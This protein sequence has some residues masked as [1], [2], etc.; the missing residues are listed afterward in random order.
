LKD[1]GLYLNFPFCLK[2]C[3]YCD[4]NSFDGKQDLMPAY[5]DA[6]KKEISGL[7]YMLTDYSIR[8]IY[9]GGGTPTLFHEDVLK[10]ILEVCNY[11]LNVS[12]DA[13]I[14][15]ESNPATLNERKLGVLR[16]SGINRLSI[17]LQ[18]S[19]DKHLLTLGRQHNAQDFILATEWAR[20][21]GFENINADVLLSLPGQS[22][23]DLSETIDMAIEASIT[24]LSLYSLRLEEKTPLYDEMLR[25]DIVL[26]EDDEDR[27][28]FHEAKD[29]LLKYG[30]DR[31]EISNFARSGMECVHNLVYWKNNEYVGCGSNAHSYFGKAR[32]ANHSG[33]KAY[34]ESVNNIGGQTR[35]FTARV[36]AGEERFDTLM[37]GL[38]LTKGVDKTEFEERFGHDINFFYKEKIDGLMVQGLLEEDGRNLY[39]TQKGLDL[40]NYVILSLMD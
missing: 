5:I 29:Q 31:Y 2:K 20:A 14:T 15:I 28:M 1:V 4:F 8:T 12:S 33:I 13:E 38:R 24:H 3:R 39:C 32:Y 22:C 7:G 16:N 25:G 36:D 18:A 10:E 37:L 17:G 9:M 11:K 30:F 34:I 35:E 19:Q 6:L 27:Q 23:K 26:P 21:E 40:Q